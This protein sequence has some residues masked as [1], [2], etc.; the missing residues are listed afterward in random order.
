MF[1]MT[2]IESL[3]GNPVEPTELSDYPVQQELF[4]MLE[5]WCYP[6]DVLYFKQWAKSLGENL[7]YR[8]RLIY[9]FSVVA[10]S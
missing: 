6:L 1:E 5:Q 7:L 10:C 4:Q 9:C 8:K 2:P 3:L